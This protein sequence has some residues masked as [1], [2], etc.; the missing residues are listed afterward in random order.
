M[1]QTTPAP[2]PRRLLPALEELAHL[3]RTG[4][5]D[6]ELRAQPDEIEALVALATRQRAR[7][8]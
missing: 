7:R 1:S 6:R 4:A 8:H 5:L 3:E 2:E